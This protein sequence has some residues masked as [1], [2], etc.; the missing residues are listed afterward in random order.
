MH[1]AR[2]LA[3]SSITAIVDFVILE[4][5]LHWDLL[6]EVMIESTLSKPYPVSQKKNILLD[7]NLERS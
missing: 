3:I 7:P 6:L 1:S 5:D 4:C 2:T